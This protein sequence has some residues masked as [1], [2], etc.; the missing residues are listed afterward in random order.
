VRPAQAVLAA[1][2]NEAQLRAAA[3]AALAEACVLAMP[4]HVALT[5][6]VE[7]ALPAAPFALG[8]LAMFV[9][10]TTLLCRFRGTANATA[11]A[12]GVSALAALSIGS[13]DLNFLIFRVLVAGIVAFRAASLGFRDWRDPLHG[14]IGWGALAMGAE[15]ALGAG[16][17]LA[18]WRI[19]L[20]MMIPLFFAASL[21]SRAITI[22]RDPEADPADARFWLGRIPVAFAVYVAGVLALAAAALRGGVLERLGSIVA[23]FASVIFTVVL[24]VLQLVLRPVFWLLSRFEVSTEAWQRFLRNVRRS[25]AT[26]RLEPSHGALGSSISRILGF[27]LFSL[28]AWGIYRSLRRLRAP[29]VTAS[30]PTHHAPVVRAPLPDEVV[31]GGGRRRRSLPA[32]RIRLWYAQALLAL[33]RHELRKDPSLTPA[34]FAREVG[35][36]LPELREH[37]DPLTRAYEDVRYGSLRVDDVTLR[38]LRAHHRALLARLRRPPGRG[39]ATPLDDE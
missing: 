35:R 39:E 19:P 22:W 10:G 36:T 13:A 38:E 21:G 31:P 23:P 17:G 28:L 3:F 27:L 16:A 11:I 20:T 5:E 14:E 6:T 34:E 4:V 12:G 30:T 25:A 8:F 7:A 2:P 32:D 18:E 26:H 37:L 15:A 33:E 9:A 29:E 24:F 1:P